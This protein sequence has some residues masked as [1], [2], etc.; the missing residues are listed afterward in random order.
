MVTWI[1][2]VIN[3]IGG[4]FDG[5]HWISSDGDCTRLD[6][7]LMAGG[8]LERAVA[9][10]PHRLG[11]AKRDEEDDDSEMKLHGVKVR[12]QWL[13]STSSFD[14]DWTFMRPNRDDA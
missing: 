10:Q 5:S 8:L 1:G 13:E 7:A 3:W 12:F 11:G 14:E 4:R 2:G 6:V 9:E